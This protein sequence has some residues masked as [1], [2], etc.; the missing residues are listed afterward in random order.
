MRPTSKGKGEEREGEW[1]GKGGGVEKEGERMGKGR[2]L[3]PLYL[4]SGLTKMLIAV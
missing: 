2:G 3:S 4:T 1:R